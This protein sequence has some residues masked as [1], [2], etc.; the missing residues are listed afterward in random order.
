MLELCDVAVTVGYGDLPEDGEGWIGVQIGTFVL[1][2]YDFGVGTFM[3][4]GVLLASLCVDIIILIVIVSCSIAFLLI[5]TW[6]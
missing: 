1:R 2:D 3:C 5:H 4:G 6:D